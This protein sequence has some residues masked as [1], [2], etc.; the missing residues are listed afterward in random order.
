LASDFEPIARI[1]AGGGPTKTRPASAQASA[2][3]AFSDRN[4]YPGCTASAP[5]RRAAASSASMSR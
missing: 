5:L 1:A 2:K 4:P 3:R